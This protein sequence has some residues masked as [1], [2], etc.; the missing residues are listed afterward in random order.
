MSNSKS[1]ALLLFTLFLTS[2]LSA[3]TGYDI[4]KMLDDKKQPDDM[5]SDMTM[6]LTSRTG[7][8]RTL[9]VHS[10]RKGEDKQIIWFLAPADDR[11]VAFLKIE[12][13]DR[14]DE[15][16]MWLP[17]FNKMRRISSSKKG[18]SF[19][20]SDLSYEDMT[21]RELDEYT[22][23]L[24][25]EEELDGEP[26]W[27]MEN[28][29]K[30]ELRSSYSKIIS[31]VRQADVMPIKE[32]FYDR[33]GNLLKLRTMEVQELKG[34]TLPTRMFVKNVQKEHSTELIFENIEVDTGVQEDLFHERNL[35]R[36]P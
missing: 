4:A 18:E 32:E 14:E 36:L 10:A 33:A 6:V 23:E 2:T 30:P 16:R 3:Q 21:T 11:G 27:L 22:Y 8:T 28:I 1:S 7:S 17:S 35:R 15:M 12:Y 9:T 19:M 24:L 31:W 13:E 26:A 25:G 20:G 5:V 34:Y 29:P